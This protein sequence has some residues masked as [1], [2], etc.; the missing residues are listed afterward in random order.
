MEYYRI[1]P[2]NKVAIVDA[3]QF[4]EIEYLSKLNT[5]EIEKK[6]K[7]LYKSYLKDTGIDIK[8]KYLTD[9]NILYNELVRVDYGENGYWISNNDPHPKRVRDEIVDSIVKDVNKRV[10]PIRKEIIEGIT[11]N[12][13]SWEDRCKRWFKIFIY[14]NIVWMIVCIVLLGFIL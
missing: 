6:A 9:K 5:E 12:I 14:S 7:E 10:Y 3:A 8:I 2:D 11:S 13:N 4:E 1:I